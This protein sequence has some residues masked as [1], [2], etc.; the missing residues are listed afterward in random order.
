M[1][2]KL[3]R[4]ATAGALVGCTAMA[5]AVTGV[6]G[7]LAGASGSAPGVTSAHKTITLGV[8]TPL[9]GAA[10]LIGKPLTDGNE[11]YFKWFNAHGGAHGWKVKLDVETDTYTPQ[12]HVTDFASEMTHILFMAQSLGSPT[13]AAI[14]STAASNKVLLGTAAQDSSFVNHKINLVQGTPYAVTVTNS[15]YYVTHTLHK[16][17]AKFAIV[18]NNTDYGKDGLK[19]YTTAMNAYHFTSVDELTAT[20]TE[21]TFTS[22]ATSLKSKDATYVVI[23]VLPE[24]AAYLIGTAAL[25][26]YHPQWILQGP[27]WSEYLMTTNGTTTGKPTA[28]EP[29]MQGAWVM[30][31]LAPWGDTSYPGM[32]RLLAA[33]AKYYPTQIPDGYYEYGFAQAWIEGALLKKV[34]KSGHITRTEV[35]KAKE[36]LGMIST[37]GLLPTASYNSKN[38]P[39]D[40]ETELGKVT[41]TDGKQGF[42]KLFKGFFSTKVGDKMTFTSS[43]TA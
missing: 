11:A 20:A 25:L 29:A 6:G 7:D 42:V 23:T 2:R 22:Q 34:V 43:S 17:S 39:A 28:A 27:A 18:Y 33:T 35:L 41:K 40:R 24:E 16:K 32:K 10:A 12:K 26:G 3:T 21:T 5:I 19:G 15:L 37:G 30:G 38:G 1:Q 36:T 31:Y 14:E 13:T 8:I 4:V 9:S